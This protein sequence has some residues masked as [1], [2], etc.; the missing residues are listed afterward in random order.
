MDRIFGFSPCYFP[1]QHCGRLL[2][3]WQAHADFFTVVIQIEKG[4][5]SSG[6]RGRDTPAFESGARSR[7][8]SA[9]QTSKPYVIG[10]GIGLSF[11]DCMAPILPLRKHR[12]VRESSVFFQYFLCLG[13]SSFNTFQ[14]HH[15]G[16]HY[17]VANTP[18]LLFSKPANR[19]G[20]PQSNH[21]CLF[22]VLC[23]KCSKFFQVLFSGNSKEA[24]KKLCV[25]VVS[26][27]FSYFKRSTETLRVIFTHGAQSLWLIVTGLDR[28]GKRPVVEVAKH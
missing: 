6:G 8:L 27:L 21:I 17:I 22:C 19:K 7:Y 4:S 26:V 12:L 14:N 2:L 24:L 1:K 20:Y 18:I 16:M 25:F 15:H 10:T 5:S 9:S 23:A 3:C 28:K 11:S 13:L